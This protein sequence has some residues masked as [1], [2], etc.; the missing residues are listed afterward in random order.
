MH[1]EDEALVGRRRML[2]MQVAAQ[3]PWRIHGSEGVCPRADGTGL[4]VSDGH[5]IVVNNISRTPEPQH[6]IAIYAPGT[7]ERA[8]IIT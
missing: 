4:N 7:W 2:G 6:Q 5:L 3:P 1:G 8:E